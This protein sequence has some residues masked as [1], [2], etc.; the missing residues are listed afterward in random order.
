MFGKG[1]LLVVESCGTPNAEA[2]NLNAGCTYAA[3]N[4]LPL[5]TARAWF[6][7]D[8]SIHKVWTPKQRLHQDT[9]HFLQFCHSIFSQE[10][11]LV[12]CSG[13]LNE[14]LRAVWFNFDEYGVQALSRTGFSEF[15]RPEISA[16]VLARTTNSA[17]RRPVLQT[18]LLVTT[19]LLAVHCLNCSASATVRTVCFYFKEVSFLPAK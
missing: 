15:L 3:D 11:F 13:F 6:S 10:N 4:A 7:S 12:H 19:A 17:V 2:L 9:A 1:W 5:V 14:A 8:W 16:L 18:S